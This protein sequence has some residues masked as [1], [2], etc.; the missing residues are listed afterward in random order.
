MLM[1]AFTANLEILVDS[2]ENEEKKLREE[3]ASMGGEI[4]SFDVP[5]ETID[6]LEEAHG[7]DDE[8]DSNGDDDRNG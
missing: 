7:D 6:A 3:M 1:N 2:L 4:E 8:D 5:S